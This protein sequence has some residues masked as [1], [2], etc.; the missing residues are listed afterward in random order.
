M[1]SLGTCFQEI[2]RRVC[3]GSEE[4]KRVL[5]SPAV[6]TRAPDF[7]EGP[8]RPSASR[9][10]LFGSG[11]TI[12]HWS[13]PGS[14][15][16]AQLMSRVSEP[17]CPPSRG[18]PLA[19][20]GRHTSTF[21]LTPVSVVMGRVAQVGHERGTLMLFLRFLLLTGRW[22]QSMQLILFCFGNNLV[23]VTWGPPPDFCAEY[24]SP[25]KARR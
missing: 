16:T 12:F 20:G 14:Q 21:P 22:C 7:A 3:A 4:R 8:P 1:S 15:K 24:L 25:F 19:L 18:P 5:G 10:G 6:L 11:N 2:P 13:L 17:A 9:A 23:S